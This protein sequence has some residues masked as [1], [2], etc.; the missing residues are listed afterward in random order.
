MDIPLVSVL[1]VTWN[2]KEDVLETVRSV[3]EQEY[4]N[5]EIVVVD[6]G[7]SDGT[8]ENVRQVFPVVKVVALDRNMGISSGRNAGIRVARGDIIF[9]L[10]SDASLA[11]DTLTNLVLRFQAE[12]E[13]GVIN[14][15]IINAYTREL[16]RGPGWVYTEKH[17]AN[18][19][20]EFPSWNFSEGGGC[21][22]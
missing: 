11:P 5:F 15:K 21:D 4:R 3:Y 14:S 13:L 19:D 10:D 12:P 20:V 17:K 6:N 16:D 7:S 2:R 1:I 9:C 18:Q 22:P 8:V